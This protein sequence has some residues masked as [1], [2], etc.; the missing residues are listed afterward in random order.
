MTA[1]ASCEQR[2]RQRQRTVS[3][4]GSDSPG[5][6]ADPVPGGDPCERLPG[7]API[8]SLEAWV[9]HRGVPVPPPVKV[10][11]W[12]S[13]G[14]AVLDIVP[15]PPSPCEPRPE[16]CLGGQPPRYTVPVQ[17]LPRR[18]R[19]PACHRCGRSPLNN[20]PR[21]RADGATL[22]R[23]R[24]EPRRTRRPA[25]RDAKPRGRDARAT[26]RPRSQEY[27]APLWCGRDTRISVSS[28][29][30]ALDHAVRHPSCRPSPTFKC[31]G[32]APLRLCASALKPQ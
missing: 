19:P 1:A 30:R 17:L 26:L 23:P 6:H 25:L 14:R 8:A 18:D 24:Y 27:W 15:E 32:S 7:T 5:F 11:F 13:S 20:P 2:Q 28:N 3:R 31:D 21:D 4:T 12:R 9:P 29:S 16:Q 10:N 22:G